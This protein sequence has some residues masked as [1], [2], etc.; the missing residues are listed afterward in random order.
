[1]I[2]F[3]P[4]PLSVSINQTRMKSKAI[5]PTLFPDF[6]PLFEKNSYKVISVI[7]GFGP[8]STIFPNVSSITVSTGLQHLCV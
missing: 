3:N 2:N 1:M 7:V 6:F 4:R 8:N 5:L